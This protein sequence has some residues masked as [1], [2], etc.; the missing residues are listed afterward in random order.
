MASRYIDGFGDYVTSGIPYK[1]DN[2]NNFALWQ[3]TPSTIASGN[4]ISSIAGNTTY[5]TKNLNDNYNNVFLGFE[6]YT[7]LLPSGVNRSTILSLDDTSTIQVSIQVDSAGRLIIANGNG[8]II[9]S[10]KPGIVTAANAIFIEL[11]LS[12]ANSATGSIIVRVNG[13][14]TENVANVVT[15][16][17]G[18]NYINQ[19]TLRQTI[20]AIIGLNGQNLYDNIYLC[21]NTGLSCNNFYGEGEAF[22]L[23]PSANGVLINFTPNGFGSNYLNV[24]S[25]SPIPLTN[26]NSSSTVNDTDVFSIGVLPVNIVSIVCAQIN[27][28]MYKDSGVSHVVQF[29]ISDGMVFL[30][31]PTNFA[32]SN[33]PIYYYQCYDIDPIT[34]TTWS[35]ALIGLRQIGYQILI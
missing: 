24:N 26:F 11:F 20:N 25:T 32:L 3:I 9:G 28:L 23:F 33:S 13:N 4:M 5:L 2:S 30:P 10:T 22:T 35:T 6:F 12:V 15:G 18:F 8:T 19:I 17:S 16:I 1:W 14:V 27:C 29:I 7:S 31:S 34:N 21:D